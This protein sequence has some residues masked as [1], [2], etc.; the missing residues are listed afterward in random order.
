MQSLLA[1]GLF[2]MVAGVASVAYSYLMAVPVDVELVPC[3][4]CMDCAAEC[5]I[6]VPDNIAPLGR[7]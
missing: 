2:L 7:P 1:L 6:P 5:A 4:P 3:E